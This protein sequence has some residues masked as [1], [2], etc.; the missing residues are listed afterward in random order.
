MHMSTAKYVVSHLDEQLGP[1]DE[2][3][4]KTKWVKGEILPIDYVYDESQQDWVL[5]AEKFPWASKIQG[6]DIMPPPPT[7]VRQETVIGRRL[8]EN[9]EH[10]SNDHKPDIGSTKVGYTLVPD[11]VKAEPAKAE[12]AKAEPVKAEPLKVEPA[13]PAPVAPARNDQ[14]R[15]NSQPVDLQPDVDQY[16]V[17]YGDARL[18]LVNGV[19]EL[20][21]S[22]LHPGKVELILADNSKLSLQE[23]LHI[24]VKPAE[25]VRVTWTLKPTLEVG[26]R[27]EVRIQVLDEKG[28]TCVAYEDQF[29]LKVTG[30][31]QPKEL[32]LKTVDGQASLDLHNEAA[33]TWELSLEYSGSKNLELPEAHSLEWQ[34]GPAARLV[35]D[36]NQEYVAGQPI[37]VQVKA[38]DSFG[39]VARQFKGT[40]VLEVKAS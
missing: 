33:E 26:H 31:A 28:H 38:V 11:V 19:G 15:M 25:P 36:G 16:S 37:K 4:L 13:K 40:V 2:Q 27:L 7:V 14:I 22:T 1:F 29:K 20:D 39:N 23:P 10:E 8:K 12:P 35:I 3:Q 32:I 30:S 34:A 9:T 6:D 18:D 17:K 24:Q 5:I 21:L